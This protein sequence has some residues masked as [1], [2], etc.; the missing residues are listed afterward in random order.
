M[1]KIHSQTMEYSK[2]RKLLAFWGVCSKR[3]V[4]TMRFGLSKVRM[5]R[6]F[7]FPASFLFFSRVLQPGVD[8]Q[9]PHILWIEHEENWDN[10]LCQ[11]CLCHSFGC[12]RVGSNPQKSPKQCDKSL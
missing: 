7:R 3:S 10:W 4:L 11:G 6:I 2:M 8:P 5:F 1:P 12:S 9:V